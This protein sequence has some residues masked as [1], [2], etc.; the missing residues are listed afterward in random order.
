MKINF[1]TVVATASIF[2]IFGLM[3]G[4]PVFDELWYGP[5]V[6]LLYLCLLFFLGY[7]SGT[8][9]ESDV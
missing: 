6:I 8:E 2:W 5:Y 4:S 9:K 3:K 7:K 1:F